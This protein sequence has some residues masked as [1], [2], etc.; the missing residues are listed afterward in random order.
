MA[1]WQTFEARRQFDEVIAA[2]ERKG[3]QVVMRRKR[4]V[5]VVLSAD[6][7]RRLKRQADANFARLL[8]QTPFGS[9]DA[10]A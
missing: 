5:A 10:Q 4:A 3:P 9:D 8:A 2:A 1:G 6:E 7:Y